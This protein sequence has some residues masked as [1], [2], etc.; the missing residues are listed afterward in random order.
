MAKQQDM[1]REFQ[2]KL[3]SYLTK[4]SGASKRLP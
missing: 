3:I 4:D 1:Q 2:N